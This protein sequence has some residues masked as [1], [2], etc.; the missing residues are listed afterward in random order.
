MPISQIGPYTIE[1]LLGE[2]GMGKVYRAH[3]SR[4]GRQV[5]IKIVR[6]DF[7]DRFERESHA[8]AAL[9]HPHVCTLYDVGPNFLAMEF[10][11]GE[12]LGERLARGKL[13]IEQALTYG[14][15]IAGALAAAHAKG[16]VH[17]DLKP[18]NIMLAKSGVK[19]L[20]FGLAMRAGPAASGNDETVTAANAVMGTPAYI[21]PELWRGRPADA[22]ADLYAL[23]VVLHEMAM[24]ERPSPAEGRRYD[25]IPARLGDV[26]ERCLAADPEERWQS[27]RDLQLELEWIAREMKDPAAPGARGHW[28][29]AFAAASVLAVLAAGAAAVAYYRT[30]AAEP[31]V[32]FTAILPPDDTRFSSASPVTL[33]PDGRSM[34]FRAVGDQSE[35]QL[36]IRA[37]DAPSPVPLPGTVGA[38]YPFWSP[39]SRWVAFYADGFLKKVDIRG[40]APVSLAAVRGAGIGG[41]WS[42]KGQIVFSA[43]YFSP[44]MKIPEDGGTPAIATVT[45]VSGGGFPW[46][47]PD[48]EHFLFASWRGS[49][50]G[51][52]R[53]GSLASTANTIVGQVDSN[54][55]YA[56]GQL[57]YLRG[58]SLVAQPFDARSLR[59]T[60]EAVL[61]V[62]QVQR[63]GALVGMGTFSA[64]Q[65]GLL[66]YRQG[67]DSTLLQLTWFDREGNVLGTLG[68]PMAYFNIRLS[69]DGK[70]L[71]ASAPDAVANFDLLAFDLARGSASRFTTDAGGEYYGVPSADGRT[72]IFN[73]TRLGN[74][75]LFRKPASGTGPEEL[76]FADETDKVPTSLSSDGRYLLYF[77]GG[78]QRYRLWRLPLVPAHAGAPLRPEPLLETSSNERWAH[79]S[80][81]DRWIVYET[82][83]SGRQ[84]IYVAPS[85]RPMEK[86]R[87][88]TDGGSYARWR[89]DG[90][91]IFYIDFQGQLQ[92]VDIRIDGDA[93]D[94]ASVRPVFTKSGSSGGGFLYEMTGD[95][96]K[97]LIAI[98]VAQAA[99]TLTLVENWTAIKR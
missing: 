13:P 35:A 55:V 11:E 37:L 52:L 78:G 59:T 89:G 54:A 62:E 83:E 75:D 9:N 63:L 95:A 43:D 92:E 40:G 19:V 60:G 10:V 12:S 32:R 2:G 25:G 96:Q 91:A 51:T 8:I 93:V 33:S 71:F 27:A 36:W 44:L 34:V 69:P 99:E 18:G 17:R 57:L 58:N 86:H 82:D 74:Y 81:D 73:S 30:P 41:S 66:A 24:G 97:A 20:D 98:P 76:V 67:G 61:V 79:F 45:E 88:S 29:L 65:T 28:P 42:P 77:T 14:A 15:Q 68:D 26:I 80:P 87:I 16:I 72:V 56:D 4:L 94:V 23:G 21:A 53:M 5:A 85:S 31:Q 47:L 70:S 48:G 90:Q 7:T 1:A 22:R 49:G 3:D 64:S 38:S 50:R 39:D 46:F 6:E 84:E